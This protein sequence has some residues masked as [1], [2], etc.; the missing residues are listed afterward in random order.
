VTANRHLERWGRLASI[1]LRILSLAAFVAAFALR[2]GIGLAAACVALGLLLIP[3]AWRRKAESLPGALYSASAD[4]LARPSRPWPGQLSIT[5]HAVAWVPSRSSRDRGQDRVLIDREDRPALRVERGPAL[6]D[7]TLIVSTADGM[8]RAF[9]MHQSR[10]LR[11]ALSAF[12]AD[13]KR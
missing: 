3:L 7:V 10:A 13:P 12:G 8:T 5:E 2:N 6:L 4:L 11:K 9:R 1:V